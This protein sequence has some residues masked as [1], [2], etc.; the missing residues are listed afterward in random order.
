VRTATAAR[1]TAKT[2]IWEARRARLISQRPWVCFTVAAQS[3]IRLP[4]DRFAA[5]S[6]PA[7]VRIVTAEAC[8]RGCLQFAGDR[9][10]AKAAAIDLSAA[11]LDDRQER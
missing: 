10:D 8:R 1:S 6:E 3:P 5:R 11:G 9:L 7:H 4:E 2:K